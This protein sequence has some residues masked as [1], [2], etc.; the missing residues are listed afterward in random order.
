[1][2]FTDFQMPILDGI[3]ATYQ[4]REVMTE[5][6]KIEREDQPKIIG[7]TGHV[8]DKFTK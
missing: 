4:M 8:Q 3:S 7:I 5:D 6:F 2:I 1:M